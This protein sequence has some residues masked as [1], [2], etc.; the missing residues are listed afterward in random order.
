[1]IW[2]SKFRQNR[3]IKRDAAIAK[4]K[5]RAE[6]YEMGVAQHIDNLSKLKGRVDIMTGDFVALERKLRDAYSKRLETIEQDHQTKCG[7]CKKG[8][9]A[10]KDKLIQLQQELS[11]RISDFQQLERKMFTFLSLVENSFENIVR[12]S[13][14]MTDA[15]SQLQFISSDVNKFLDDNKDLLELQP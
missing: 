10:E 7:V 3:K 11:Q 8:I 4:N 14:R 15:L 12:H 2:L 1:M 9:E 5:G 13:S 6:G